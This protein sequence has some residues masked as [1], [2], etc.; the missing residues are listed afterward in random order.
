M[1]GLHWAGLQSLAWFRM[2]QNDLEAMA[3]DSAAELVKI[4]ASNLGGEKPCPMCH[5][6]MEESSGEREDGVPKGEVRPAGPLTLTALPA[7]GFALYP[8][9]AQRLGV[10]VSRETDPAA[11]FDCPPSPPP[12]VLGA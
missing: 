3:P 7:G 10:L 1:L 12:R 8:P 11:L 2:I 5:A 6:I 9:A 4:V